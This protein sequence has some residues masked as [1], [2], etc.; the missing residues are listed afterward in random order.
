MDRFVEGRKEG[1][2]SVGALWM[3]RRWMGELVGGLSH[4]VESK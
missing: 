3:Q 1:R 4:W 2:K